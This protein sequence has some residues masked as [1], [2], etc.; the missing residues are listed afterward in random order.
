M[1]RSRRRFGCSGLDVSDADLEVLRKRATADDR[2]LGSLIHFILAGRISN[3][4]PEPL[5]RVDS[6]VLAPF[7]CSNDRYNDPTDT[8]RRDDTATTTK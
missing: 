1:P 5:M 8:P 6:D 4:S 2:E 7:Q 3:D